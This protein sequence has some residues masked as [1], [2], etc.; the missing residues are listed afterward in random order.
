MAES[1]LIDFTEREQF[2]VSYYR[3][4]ELSAAWRNVLYDLTI[5][6]VSAVCVGLF[7]IQGELGYGL[8]GYAIVVG[9]LLYFVIE[10]ARWNRDYRNIVA[11]YD[12]KLRALAGEATSQ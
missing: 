10:G 3:S 7:L 12:A 5:V 2:I 9:R 1:D 4:A 6:T 8:A 11:K